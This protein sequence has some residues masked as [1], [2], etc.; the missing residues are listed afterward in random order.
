MDY[1]DFLKSLVISFFESMVTSFPA[2]A[3]S[4]W[5]RAE[6][7]RIVGLKELGHQIG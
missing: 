2:R 3:E 4:F 7:E 6:V 1:A 5:A